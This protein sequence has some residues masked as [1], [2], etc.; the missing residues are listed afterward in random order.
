MKG[1]FR[2]FQDMGMNADCRMIF[3]IDKLN[4]I[5]PPPAKSPLWG[6]LGGRMVNIGNE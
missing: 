3:G 2:V 5:N 6:G 4:T 1:K